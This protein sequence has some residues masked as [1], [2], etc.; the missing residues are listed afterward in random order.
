MNNCVELYSACSTSIHNR[1]FGAEL[2]FQHLKVLA[3]LFRV[4]PVL[5]NYLDPTAKEDIYELDGS[6]RFLE[7]IQASV[8]YSFGEPVLVDSRGHI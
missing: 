8:L 3:N 4:F 1:F 6:I 7:T 2:F 5:P